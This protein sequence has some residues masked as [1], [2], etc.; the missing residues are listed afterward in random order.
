MLLER[1]AE[2][3]GCQVVDSYETGRNQKFYSRGDYVIQTLNS[4]LQTRSNR[5]RMLGFIS[6]TSAMVVTARNLERFRRQ[7]DSIQNNAVACPQSW[8]MDCEFKTQGS[9]LTG[10]AFYNTSKRRPTGHLR[11]L[12]C[13]RR[14]SCSERPR[15][16]QVNGH[17]RNR[18][19]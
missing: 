15:A 5:R 1:L 7:I 17:H 10:A 2:L 4:E 3:I 16:I 9:Y 19:V 11:N 8:G 6:T 18:A 14:A 13:T 12:Y